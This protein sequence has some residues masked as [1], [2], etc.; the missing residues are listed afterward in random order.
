MKDKVHFKVADVTY[1]VVSP[2][3]Q[4][5]AD[6]DLVYKSSYSEAIRFGALTHSEATR[7]IKERKIW[8][9][10]DE[11]KAVELIKSITMLGKELEETDEPAK[12]FELIEQI[13]LK[14]TELLTLNTKKNSVLDNTAESYADEKRLQHYVASCTLN[15]QGKQLYDGD[16]NKLIGSSDSE[17]AVEAMRYMIQLLANDGEDFRSNWPDY[18]WKKAHGVVDD[19][20]E[21]IA[22]AVEKLLEA[23][24]AEESKPAKPT[25]RKRKPRKKT[26]TK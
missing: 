18:K 26:A 25:P 3:Q 13:E 21:P 20:L 5:I 24:E 15:A 14:R 7:I 12:A 11:E 4:Q 2:T 23:Q 10:K 9:T 17:V 16:I 19:Q 22:G 6:A 8:T 1:T